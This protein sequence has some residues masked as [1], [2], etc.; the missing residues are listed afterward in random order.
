MSKI[1]V[2]VYSP[3][4]MKRFIDFCVLGK[5][6]SSGVGFETD[7]QNRDIRGVFDWLHGRQVPEAHFFHT[8]DG[9]PFQFFMALVQKNDKEKVERPWFIK[10]PV[11]LPS[12]IAL[13]SDIAA[14]EKEL[15][16]DGR[17]G[18][19]SAFLPISKLLETV[20]EEDKTLL[21]QFKAGQAHVKKILDRI[22][23]DDVM[24]NRYLALLRSDKGIKPA[25]VL[26]DLQAKFNITNEDLRLA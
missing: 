2:L 21:A 6:K 4:N 25:E 18:T 24:R 11:E 5:P 8:L 20:Q 19:L 13:E 3:I 9:D 1:E 12:T 14:V 23:T 26:K 22:G 16:F 10:V 15:T 7:D 17:F